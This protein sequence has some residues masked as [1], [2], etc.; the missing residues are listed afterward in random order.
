AGGPSGRPD[1]NGPVAGKPDLS[2]KL[3]WLGLAAVPSSLMLGVTSYM[4]HDIATFPLFWVI[5]L[6]LYLLTFIIA[7]AKLPSV[8]H[9]I[10]T[11]VAPVLVLLLVFVMMAD[12]VTKNWTL[13]SKIGLHLLVF[14]A[15]ALVLHGELAKTRPAPE[16]LTEF[17]LWMSL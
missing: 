9:T 11:L 10:M 13:T 7:F 4:V 14:F 5:P 16:Y 17:Y 12:E 3:R 6:A 1:S 15:C 8:F 2:R